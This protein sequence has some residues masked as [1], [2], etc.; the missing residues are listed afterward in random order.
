MKFVRSQ[1]AFYSSVAN[2][3]LCSCP[4]ARPLLELVLL[5]IVHGE[6]LAGAED[7]QAT[8]PSGWQRRWPSNSK[9]SAHLPRQAM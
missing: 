9:D 6:G 5:E 2:E 8:V 1:Q 3:T 7:A 4:W